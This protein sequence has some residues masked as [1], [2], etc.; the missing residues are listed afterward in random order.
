MEY[1]TVVCK[2]VIGG[3]PNTY[4]M[5]VIFTEEA[6]NLIRAEYNKLNNSKKD[7]LFTIRN[8]LFPELKDEEIANANYNIQVVLGLSYGGC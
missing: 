8:N 6:K 7:Y 4:Y 5:Q 3:I 1:Y 2:E